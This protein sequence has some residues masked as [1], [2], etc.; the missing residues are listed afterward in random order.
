[1]DE[2][3]SK[4]NDRIMQLEANSLEILG[5][6]NETL[7]KI[8]NEESSTDYRVAVIKD[9]QLLQIC[10]T[11]AVIALLSLILWRIW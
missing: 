8:H 11:V 2:K 3:T 5:S 1:M 6:I 4:D 7:Y 9:Y 10:L